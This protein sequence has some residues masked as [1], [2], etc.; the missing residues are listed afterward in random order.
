MLAGLRGYQFVGI[1]SGDFQ[2]IK[3]CL[4]G[5]LEKSISKSCQESSVLLW[6]MFSYCYMYE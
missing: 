2:K 6:N 1:L 4:L 3:T 5:T